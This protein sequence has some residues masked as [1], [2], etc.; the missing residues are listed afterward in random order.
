MLATTTLPAGPDSSCD[1]YIGVEVIEFIQITKVCPEGGTGRPYPRYTIVGNVNTPSHQ[2]NHNM[3]INDDASNLPHLNAR[4]PMLSLH[5]CHAF[6]WRYGNRHSRKS[7]PPPN[8][9]FEA[10]C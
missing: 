2:N 7:P 8:R 1:V 6:G 4:L 3:P 9:P 10:L 5:G